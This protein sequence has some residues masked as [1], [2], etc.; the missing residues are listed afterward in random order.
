MLPGGHVYDPALAHFGLEF[1]KLLI[2]ASN[3]RSIDKSDLI[4][5]QF[6][7]KKFDQ[8]GSAYRVD[9][10]R[11]CSDRP[12]LSSSCHRQATDLKANHRA[13]K[14]LEQ[15]LGIGRVIAEIATMRALLL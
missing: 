9:Q 11:A 14:G 15:H 1:R 5:L 6:G 3:H 7:V 4:G 12:A 10:H 8:I 2:S 13:T